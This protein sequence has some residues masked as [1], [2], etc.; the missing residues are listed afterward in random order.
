MDSITLTALSKIVADMAKDA[1]DTV[2]AGSYRVN[3][4]V[5]INVTGEVKV[6]EDTE[7]T[8]TCSIPVKE[9]LALF[10]ARAGFTR[11]HSIELLRSCLTDAL[12]EGV[13][14]V[15]AVDAAADID[16]AF[17]QA[18]SDLTA[19]LPKTP[20]KGKVVVKAALTEIAG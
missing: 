13:E 11:E 9:V 17:K 2:T 14:G 12:N 18:V 15:G 7:K 20:V 16:V 6:S 1:R 10:I 19:S 8:P 3:T 4:T 5:T